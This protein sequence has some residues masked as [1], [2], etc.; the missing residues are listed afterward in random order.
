MATFVTY[1]T[2]SGESGTPTTS[3]AISA[4]N[5]VAGNLIC[6]HWSGVGTPSGVPTDTAGN[7]YTLIRNFLDTGSALNIYTWYAKNIS[8]N[9]SNV[10][11]INYSSGGYSSARAVQYSGLHLTTP[12][13]TSTQD[14]FTA[15][16]SFTTASF[17]T[18]GAGV[19]VDFW[20]ASGV[21]FTV[22]ANYTKR[23]FNYTGGMQDRITSGA[24]TGTT[25]SIT[26]ASSTAYCSSIASFL[27][28]A[29]NITV[30]PS[31]VTGSFATSAPAVTGTA[32]ITA[33]ALS[34]SFA[35]QSPTVSGD[36]NIT[37]TAISG[38]FSMPTASVQTPDAY[39]SPSAITGTFSMPNPVVVISEVNVTVNP[40]AQTA[41]FS[42][43]SSTVAIVQSITVSPSFLI[44]TFSLPSSIITGD[45]WQNKFTTASGTWNNK[46]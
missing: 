41:T 40:S 29:T 13:D 24:L 7:T 38:T 33:T 2:T 14:I 3:I 44:G 31:A 1:A 11:T 6:V 25:S 46:Y 15:N 34:G 30:S 35:T 22:G 19:I 42:L 28:S 21:D 16:T 20:G 4:F 8:G 26:T 17:N 27:D 10:I 18:A 39:V 43:P 37:A 5:A 9:A 36:A 32:N 45:K 12:L 23:G